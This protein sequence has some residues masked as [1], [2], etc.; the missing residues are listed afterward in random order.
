MNSHLSTLS[1]EIAKIIRQNGFV[2]FAGATSQGESNT[3]FSRIQKYNNFIKKIVN[4]PWLLLSKL[5]H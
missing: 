4:T 1:L 5:F 2:S 3:E